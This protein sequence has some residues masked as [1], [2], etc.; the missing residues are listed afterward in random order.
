MVY[1]ALLRGINVGG[2]NKIEMGRLKLT[3]ESIGCKKVTTYINTGNII[4][5]SDLQEPETL[6]GQLEKAILNDFRLAIKVLLR[7][8]AAIAAICQGV[9]ARWVN[10][11]TMKTDVMF[12]WEQFDR[13]EVAQQLVIQE[14]DR[15][16]YFPG[17]FVWNVDREQVTRSGMMKLVGTTLYKHMTIRNINTVRKVYDIIRSYENSSG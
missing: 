3:F 2:N 7:D 4:F 9:P 10:D 13:P 17:A 8:A 6:A 11:T 15:V 16:E 14:V 5:E 12:L 1:L